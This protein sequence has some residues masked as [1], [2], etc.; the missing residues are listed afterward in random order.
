MHKY[1]SK[2]TNYLSNE[3]LKIPS[4]TN[5][6]AINRDDKVIEDFG[7]EWEKFS[8]FGKEEI[9]RIGNDYFALIQNTDIGKHSSALDIGCGTGRW[10]YYIS[11]YINDEEL[12]IKYVSVQA[13][14]SLLVMYLQLNNEFGMELS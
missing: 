11:Q 3:T 4:F 9:Q 8:D 12:F 6:S 5:N 1:I 2:V 10:A 13:V 14:N 7:D